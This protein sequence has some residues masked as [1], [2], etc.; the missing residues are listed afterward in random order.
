MFG[1]G[2]EELIGQ[3]GEVVYPSAES[4]AAFG[5]IAGPVLSAGKQRSGVD[6]TTYD[7]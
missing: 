1:W 3:P 7:R 5:R 2:P 6:S 4:Y